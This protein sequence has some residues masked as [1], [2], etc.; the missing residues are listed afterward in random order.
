MVQVRQ[1]SA[2]ALRRIGWG[3]GREKRGRIGRRV[4]KGSKWDGSDR[5]L[6]WDRQREL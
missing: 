4:G 6:A 5:K 3:G 2:V 1:S